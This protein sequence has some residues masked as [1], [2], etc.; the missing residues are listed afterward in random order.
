MFTDGDCKDDS[1]RFI[2]PVDP[3]QT[4]WYNRSD[5]EYLNIGNDRISS[6][7]IPQGYALALYKD[8]GWTGNSTVL[9]GPMWDSADFRMRC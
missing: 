6:V 4:S 1:G 2:S 5:M 3:A 9:T 7:M 8:D